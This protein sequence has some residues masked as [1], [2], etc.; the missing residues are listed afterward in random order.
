M[1]LALKLFE[2]AHQRFFR[3]RSVFLSRQI[4]LSCVPIFQSC[5]RRGRRARRARRIH[6]IRCA[7]AG[8]PI[9]LLDGLR[10]S[11]APA[12]APATLPHQISES[13]RGLVVQG[14]GEVRSGSGHHRRA[15]IENAMESAGGAADLD[16]GEGRG[17]E[18]CAGAG[19]GGGAVEVEAVAEEESDG[20]D[21]R[22]FEEPDGVDLDGDGGGIAGEE[23]GVDAEDE[24]VVPGR[25]F[26]ADDVD[27]CADLVRRIDPHDGVGLETAA[28][29]GG[30]G[31]RLQPLRRDQVDLQQ[32]RCSHHRSIDR[33]STRK[34]R[35]ERGL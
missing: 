25:V 5:G 21:E 7:V 31:W 18:P 15:D 33:F 20:A 22:I 6:T 1:N 23:V 4:L 28:H 8:V 24:L 34:S 29:G 13:D 14:G 3:A 9:G 35:T 27:T 19:G 12:P 2:S 16:G 32:V 17:A 11:P 30:C 10:V 26:S